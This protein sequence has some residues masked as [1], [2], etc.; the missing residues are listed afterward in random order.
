MS[1]SRRP[2]RPRRPRAWPDAP[3]PVALAATIAERD[4]LAWVIETARWCGWRA[5]HP[6]LSVRSEPGFP[7]LLLAKPGEPLLLWELKSEQG[8]LTPAQQRWLDLLQRVPGIEVAVWRPSQRDQMVARLT[9]GLGKG[10][11]ATDAAADA[12]D[13]AADAGADADAGAEDAAAA[14][15]EDDAARARV[16]S[17]KERTV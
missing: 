9:L 1:L 14:A 8:R 17:R 3:R 16:L 4:F 13:A 6:W 11:T 12:E 5:Y 7:D 2:R 15:A 10:P